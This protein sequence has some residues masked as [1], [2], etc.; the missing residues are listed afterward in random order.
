M[1]GAIVWLLIF[2]WRRRHR[3]VPRIEE[4]IRLKSAQ[5]ADVP[6]R[7][8]VGDAVGWNDRARI[9]TR[10]YG[11]AS[12]LSSEAAVGSPVPTFSELESPKQQKAGEVHELAA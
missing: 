11:A 12:E 1:L 3:S 7:E 9:D 6:P 5:Y 2:I 10:G 8:D 4:Q